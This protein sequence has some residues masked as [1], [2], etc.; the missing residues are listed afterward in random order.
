MIT[1]LAQGFLLGPGASTFVD[2]YA[3]LWDWIWV[4]TIFFTVLNAGLM[5]LFVA[6]YRQ[7]GKADRDKKPH[8]AHHSN[9]LEIAWSIPPLIVVIAVFGWGF[10]GYMD[11]VTLPQHGQ[12]IVVTAWKWGW[13]FTYPNGVQDGNLYLPAGEDVTFIL[14]A[15]D[16]LHSFYIPQARIKKDC[17]PGRYNKTWMHPVWDPDSPLIEEWVLQEEDL[18]KGKERIAIEAMVLDVY[19]TEYCGTGHSVMRVKCI[20]MQPED[21]ETWMSIAQN[22]KDGLTP[23]EIGERLYSVKACNTCHSLDGSSGNGPTWLNLYG[24]PHPIPGVDVADEEYLR[25]AILYPGRQIVPGWGNVMP[26]I[27]FQE[28]EVGALI[29]FIK[30]QSDAWEGD[31]SAPVPADGDTP[32]PTDTPDALPAEG[33]PDAAPTDAQPTPAAAPEAQ[34]DPV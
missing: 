1:T 24:N 12:E 31:D 27:S 8:G 23:F 10:R 11:M 2:S 17:V 4:I 34:G 15:Q 32:A 20:V 21:Y 14:E 26:V 13:Q 16:V 9:T 29:E 7:K 30:R 5:V 18:D 6:L 22:W 3:W 33:A 28:G 19:C 25:E